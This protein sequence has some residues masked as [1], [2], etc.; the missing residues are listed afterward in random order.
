MKKLIAIAAMAAC[1]AALAVESANIVGYQN[2]PYRQK[3]Q[4]GTA[5]FNGVGSTGIGIQT[6]VPQGANVDGS[7]NIFIQILNENNVT[8][9]KFFWYTD[10]DYGTDCGKD[11]WFLGYDTTE[12]A[13]YTLAPGETYIL[14]SGNG[15]ITL[16]SS[17]EVKYPVELSFRQKFQLGG[18][19]WP[20]T[21]SLKDLVPTGA[22]V[23]GSGNIF[24]QIL[25]ENNVT[26][27][28]FFWY[29]DDDYGTDCGKDGWFL[30]YDTTDLADYTFSAGEGFIFYSGNGQVTLTYPELAL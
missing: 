19:F 12:L 5:T 6:L 22:N 2:N 7:G 27:K 4:L 25:D 18:N 8:I 13:D 17:G 20:T 24:I 28:K 21:M 30:G 3:F 11:G 1:G 29:T 26:I 9:K 10:D 14:Y 16:Q 23:D 15:V